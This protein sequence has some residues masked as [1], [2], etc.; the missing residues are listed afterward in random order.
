[1][2]RWPSRGH[3]SNHGHRH[4]FANCYQCLRL[5]RVKARNPLRAAHCPAQTVC[6][7]R[8]LSRNRLN[9]NLTTVSS[10]DLEHDV[11]VLHRLRHLS[12][13]GQLCARLLQ[14]LSHALMLEQHRNADAMNVLGGLHCLEDDE[15]GGYAASSEPKYTGIVC[16]IFVKVGTANVLK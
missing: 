16:A 10:D 13:L 11:D 7:K 14:V 15:A 8:D 2:S 6:R 9:P 3:A 4:S 12:H 1:M 5:A